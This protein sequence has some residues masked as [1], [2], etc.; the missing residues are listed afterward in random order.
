MKATNGSDA[1]LY[2]HGTRIDDILGQDDGTANAYYFKNHLGSVMQMTD[3]KM[4]GET[5]PAFG[6]PKTR[7]HNTD[8]KITNRVMS[9]LNALGG[10][11]SHHF[12][13]YFILKCVILT[14]CA[15]Q[16]GSLAQLVEPSAHNR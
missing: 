13:L 5:T 11:F 14:V 10:E 16:C 9:P 2:Y 6:H 12:F 1:Y 7:G 8:L 3:G 4:P 15:G